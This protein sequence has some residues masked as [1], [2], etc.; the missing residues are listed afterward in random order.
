MNK[1][2]PELRFLLLCG[3][4]LVAGWRS[5]GEAAALAWRDDGYSHILLVLPI[6][7]GLVSLEWRSW[8]TV[9]E[10]NF[11]IGAVLLGAAVVVA[12]LAWRGSS[13]L[14]PDERLS[15]SVLA[16]VTWWIGAFVL[17]FGTRV[18]KAALFPLAFLLLMVP[19]PR[20]VLDWIIHLLQQWSTYAA[21]LLFVV[22]G[23]PVAQDGF[24]LSIPD[25]T[26]EVAKECSSIRSSS[27][28]LVT[29]IV[30]AQLFLRSPWRKALV[31]ALAVP[32]S[33]AKNGLRI[34]T[35]AMLGTRVDPGF[36]TGK[37]H[38]NGGVIFFLIALAAMFLVLRLLQRGEKPT[39][40]Q[41]LRAVA[42]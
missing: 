1:L 39:A 37:L 36:L 6:A 40:G 33:V 16:L 42:P 3:V 9:A 15:V 19:F 14:H 34:F 18:S 11:R 22:A 24:R 17:C 32:V 26:V 29:T 35:I 28:L 12:G 25:L 30:L 38:H 8:K 10:A 41:A 21:R 20:S 23:V 4:S 31:I 7:A 27:M 13:W 5:L 2:T